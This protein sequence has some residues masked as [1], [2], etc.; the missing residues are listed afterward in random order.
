MDLGNSVARTQAPWERAV[1]WNVDA[2]MHLGGRKDDTCAP[3]SVVWGDGHRHLRLG[4]FN[5]QEEKTAQAPL[6]EVL[7]KDTGFPG[8][9]ETGFAPQ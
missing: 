7:L 8:A 3:T 6:E 9:S 1:P 2:H 4:S 5:C